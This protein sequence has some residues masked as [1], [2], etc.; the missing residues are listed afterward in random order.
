MIFLLLLLLLHGAWAGP[1]VLPAGAVDAEQAQAMFRGRRIALLVGP[2]GFEDPGFSQLRYT[3]SD[4]Q[5]LAT[6][7]ADPALGRFDEVRTLTGTDETDLATVRQAMAEVSQLSLS[8]DDTVFVYFSTHGTLARD[9]EGQLR[10]Y[11][12]LSD[13]RLNDVRGSALAHDELLAWLERLPSRRKVLLLATCHSG[14]GK[15]VFSPEL[16]QELEGT[17]GPAAPPLREVSEAVVLIGVCA[18]NEVAR[19]S[20]QLAHDIYTWFFLE[21]LESADLDGDGAVTVTEAHDHARRRT[22]EFTGGAQRAYARAEILGTDPVVLAGERRRKGH[23]LLGSYRAQL[24][25][26]KVKVDGLVKGQLPGQVAL[27]PGRHRVELLTPDEGRVVARHRLHLREG[28][29]LNVDRLLG[30]DRLRLSGGLAWHAY[31]DPIPSGPAIC[32][33]LHLP[34]W[35]GRGWELVG[36]GG[37]ALRWPRPVLDGGL[38]L[39]RALLPGDF[40]LRLGMGL[41]A[42]LLRDD[43]DGMLFQD[44][45]LPAGQEPLLEPSVGPLPSLSLAWMPTGPVWARLSL[46][47]GY[48]W[49]TDDG[50]WNHL[51]HARLSLMAGGRF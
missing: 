17:K 8:H 41:Q 39:E 30:R 32:G 21:A 9:G 28:G 37:A 35:P 11:L 26:F 10:Q 29:R 14:Q 33:E 46:A 50:Q 7:L 19:E 15:S 4:A 48:L 2:V 49:F 20:E 16:A 51:W 45:P 44:E 34:R 36:N 31:R 13:S 22:Y 3:D 6:V 43:P 23:P 27:P 42:Y 38:S 25:G 47:G 24:E 40:Q 12:V 18:W 1:K 5:A